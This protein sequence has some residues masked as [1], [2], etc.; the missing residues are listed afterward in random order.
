MHVILI[1]YK[2][3]TICSY[4]LVYDTTAGIFKHMHCKITPC[5]LTYFN[6]RD[7]MGEICQFFKSENY[8]FCL[9]CKNKLQTL[10][11]V[12]QKF[13]GHT[14]LPT[15]VNDV[16]FQ[17]ILSLN[18]PFMGM[19]QHSVLITAE[20]AQHRTKRPSWKFISYRC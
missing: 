10:I 9:L 4:S 17:W 15:V 20:D 8:F 11:R 6:V 1:L 3:C 19:V 13:Q 14:A 12:F 7:A 16:I 5:V 2:A 18:V